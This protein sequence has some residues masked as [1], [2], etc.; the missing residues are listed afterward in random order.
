MSRN[1]QVKNNQKSPFSFL[2]SG[3]GA[4]AG[5]SAAAAGGWILYS[6]LVINHNLPLPYAMNAERIEFESKTAGKISYYVDQQKP[7]RPLVLIHSINAAASA[8]EM[9]PL[10]EQFRL[11]RPV[12]ALDLPGYGF[13]DRQRQHY[14]P[15]LFE[16]AITDMLA[17]QVGEPAD[18]VALSLGCEFAARSAL[19]R[20]ELY[21]S[22]AFISPTGFNLPVNKRTGGSDSLYG[23]FTLP[24]WRRPLYDL[25]TTR[26]SIQFFLQKSFVGPVPPSLVNYAYA[27]SHRPGAEHAPLAFISGKLFTPAVRTTIYE[28]ITTPSLVIFDR[29]GYTRFD[30]LASLIK[31]NPHWRAVKLAPSFGLPQFEKPK[32]TAQELSVFWKEIEPQVSE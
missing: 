1:K 30:T 11:Q 25:I 15:L 14:D 19:R 27:T 24:L 10:F 16:D 9:R 28:L 6:N 5:V 20:P 4:L 22:L 12:Y 3:V 8:H 7:G 13:S 32:E 26:G 29:D 17:S 18:V 2:G 21:H 23:L 31:T